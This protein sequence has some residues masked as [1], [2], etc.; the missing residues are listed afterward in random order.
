MSDTLGLKA[1]RA[2]INAKLLPAIDRLLIAGIKMGPA[3]KSVAINKV[4]QL[5]PKWTRG[6]CWRR[7][8]QL[9]R[10]PEFASASATS[11]AAAEPTEPA[12]RHRGATRAWTATDDDHLLNWAGYEPV[13]KIAL[14]LRRSEHAVRF[15]MAA[16]GMSAKVTDGWSLRSLRKLLRV[17]PKR[18]R[19]L[20]GTGRLRVRDPRVTTGSFVGFLESRRASLDAG[21]EARWA[22][23]REKCE[24][25]YSWERVASILGVEVEEVQRLICAGILKI[26]DP[27]V[28]D[29][30]FEEFCRKHGNE[31]SLSL[32][33]PATGKW[34]VNEYG[35]PQ[36]ATRSAV[37]PR[38]QKHALSI[39]AC[40][41]GKKIAGNAYFRHVKSCEIAKN[42]AARRAVN[43][44]AQ[45]VCA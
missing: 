44:R 14:R 38:A 28:T 35:V 42:V 26:V 5:V 22:A 7:L 9:R 23:V 4:L 17:S 11:V 10:L 43:G 45:Q 6:N 41:C 30:Q 32:L 34:L 31:I 21:A 18:I 15:R 3:G 36:S 8:R 33:D 13:K 20:I 16:L 12:P 37:T 29:R 19:S 24:E 40:E 25:G 2:K 39:R 1:N 27:F